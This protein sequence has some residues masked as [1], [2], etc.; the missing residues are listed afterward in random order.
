MSLALRPARP[1]DAPA[2]A[3]VHVASWRDAY[4]GLVPPEALAS[5]TV[6][7]RTERWAAM[8]AEPDGRVCVLA[9][10]DGRVAGFHVCS[11]PDPAG[12]AELSGLYVHPR[13]LSRGVGSALL[14]DCLARLRRAGARTIELWVLEGNARARAF[15]ER[16][17]FVD[18]GERQEL[19][20]LRAVQAR[21]RRAA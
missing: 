8:L 4:A 10:L 19:A 11:R 1:E 12:V 17:G 16:H 2:L 3:E 9:E 18:T 15:Y 7:R 6:E 21:Y 14:A 13:A 20:H 5:F